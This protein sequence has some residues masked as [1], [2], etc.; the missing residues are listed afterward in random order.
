MVDQA[1][2]NDDPVRVTPGVGR[3]RLAL[4]ASLSPL[5]GLGMTWHK[6]REQCPRLPYRLSDKF[7]WRW[8]KPL[9]ETIQISRPD[10][11]CGSF[12]HPDKHGCS[13]SQ[14]GKRFRSA[15]SPHSP[16]SGETKQSAQPC[17]HPRA[18][19]QEHLEDMHGRTAYTQY[20]CRR[21]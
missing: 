3:R 6:K 8:L 15:Y 10:P 9:K 18:P 2:L 20:K 12:Q 1:D 21:S 5:Q 14:L 16:P 13:R 11:C 17:S 7:S 19:F 4:Q